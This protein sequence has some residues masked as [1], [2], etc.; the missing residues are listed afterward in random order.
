[1]K[2]MLVKSIP[3]DSLVEVCSQSMKQLSLSLIEYAISKTEGNKSSCDS[4]NPLHFRKHSK[5]E[6]ERRTFWD[7]VGISECG[8]SW[9]LISINLLNFILFLINR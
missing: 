5:M 1:M 3:P 7:F 8:I 2:W 9:K 6:A 4:A